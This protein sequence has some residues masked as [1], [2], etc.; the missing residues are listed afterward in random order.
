MPVL[1]STSGCGGLLVKKTSAE[2]DSHAP[3]YGEE[4]LKAKATVDI[5]GSN[6]KNIRGKAVILAR[7]P[8]LFRIELLGPFNMTA[9]LILSDGD[10]IY[11][12]SRGGARYHYTDDPDYPYPFTAV[13]LVAFLFG[14]GDIGVSD[15]RDDYR[16]DFD[17]EDRITVLEKLK[18]GAV[19]FKASMGDFRKN[20]ERWYPHNIVIKNGVQEIHIRYKSL[21]P[22]AIIDSGLFKSP[23]RPVR[24][25]PQS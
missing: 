3:A 9:A 14:D 15:A 20:G 8:D 18:D 12:Y 4:N 1:L 23:E 11:Y 2:E 10:G 6:G 17:N 22:G 16:I 24:D 13:E 25:D 7:T 19:L 5:T 21:L